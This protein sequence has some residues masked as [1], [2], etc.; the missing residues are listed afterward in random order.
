MDV[1]YKQNALELDLKLDA[2]H[3]K[4]PDFDDVA[5]LTR[6]TQLGTE[7]LE[8]VYKAIKF[9]EISQNQNALKEQVKAELKAELESNRGAVTSVVGGKQNSTVTPKVSLTPDQKRVADGM[10]LSYE[11]YTKWLG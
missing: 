10:G 6:A 4:Y 5:V 3:N 1:V 8:F 9:D 2:L 7:D 11:E